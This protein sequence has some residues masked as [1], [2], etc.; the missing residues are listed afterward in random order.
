VQF[1]GD[2][3]WVYFGYPYAHEDDVAR[4]IRSA[5]GMTEAV[6]SLQIYGET[7]RARIGI[8]TGLCVAGNMR[9]AASGKLPESGNQTTD[10]Q[11][12]AFGDPPNLAARLHSLAKPGSIVVA[13]ETRSLV[14]SLF[15]FEDLGLHEL[16]GFEE[17][18]RAWRVIGESGERSRFKALRSL[19]ISPM[20]NRHTEQARLRELWDETCNGQGQV[21]H[22]CGEPGIGKSRLVALVADNIIGPDQQC[23]WFHCASHLQGSA[24]A[25]VSSYLQLESGNLSVG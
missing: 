17:P 6:E 10:F 1:A 21:I 13:D 19:T 22:L 16:K 11:I 2:A 5:L 9:Q 18:M 4:A 20:V 23:W 7:L 14:G 3:I 25:P 8:A 12:T 24:F 15:E